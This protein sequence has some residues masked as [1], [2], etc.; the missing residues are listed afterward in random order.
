[1]TAV[2]IDS[3]HNSLALG[4][5]ADVV[6]RYFTFFNLGEYQRVAELF[7]PTGIL[8]PPFESPVEGKDRILDYLLKEA[9]GMQVSLLSAE[10]KAVEDNQLQVDL[11]GS[12]TALVFKVN[13]TWQFVVTD[14]STIQSVRVDLVATLE[15][16]LKIRPESAT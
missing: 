6:N 13:V 4:G 15:E 8:Y 16:L 7:T 2:Q 10:T 5:Q 14:D 12:V 11:R 1:M 3:Q 9:E